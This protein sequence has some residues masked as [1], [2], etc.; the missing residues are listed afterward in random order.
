[1]A[2][3]AALTPGDLLISHRGVHRS[4]L[5]GLLLTGARLRLVPDLSD[6]DWGV[7]WP[8]VGKLVKAVRQRRPRAVLVTSPTYTGLA[9]DLSP[10]RSACAE[11]GTLLLIDAAHGAHFGLG[12]LPPLAS[13]VRPDLVVFGLHKSGGAPTAGAVLGR[14][15]TGVSDQRWLAARRAVGTSSPSYPLMAAIEQAVLGLMRDGDEAM[16]RV[17]Q[18]M[19]QL[20]G[21]A[22][23]RPPVGMAVDPT[24]VTVASDGAKSRRRLAEL[25]VDAEYVASRHLLLLGTLATTSLPTRLLR[26]VGEQQRPRPGPAAAVPIQRRMEVRPAFFAPSERLA[27]RRAVGR[28]LATPLAPSPP[29]IPLLWPGEVLGAEAVAELLAAEQ[30]GQLVLGMDEG[31]VAVVREGSLAGIGSGRG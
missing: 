21:P 31:Q 25:A 28:V 13:S 14:I 6:V 19:S 1:M 24:R 29:G 16:E 8:D 26:W 18:V 30:A 23:Y 2:L 12:A 11:S 5:Q 9:P 7:G 3:L 10:L 17:S 20:T 22:V 4:M 15:G 27:V